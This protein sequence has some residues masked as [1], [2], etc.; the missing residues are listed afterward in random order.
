MKDELDLHFMATTPPLFTDKTRF[1]VGCS[2]GKDSAAALIWM[3]HESGIDP[4]Q[5]LSSF[6]DIKNDHQWTLAHVELLSKRVHPIETIHPRVGFFD[7]ALERHRFPSAKA[8]FCTEELKIYTT[9][10]HIQKLKYQGF[11]VIAVS[12]VRADESAG[13]ANKPEWDYSG[14]LLCYQWRPLIRW[15][16]DDVKA[17]H[18]KYGIPLNPL[19]DIGAQRV[20]CWPC[21]MSRKEEIRT[22]A[23]KFPER[24]DEIR[25]AER[26]FERRYG[27]YSSFFASD[28]IPERFRSKPHQLDDGT[29]IKVCTIDDVVKWSM[30]GN[31]A[32]GSYLDEEETEP[33]SCKSGFCE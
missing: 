32:Q 10:D 23:L 12:G 20:G 28:K 22:I 33:V 21:I 29:W 6:C 18:A 9:Q 30:T 13:R 25:K 14:T 3:R 11:D 5:I 8:R 7:L 1:H 15:T 19:Y 26:E 16:I 17:I 31:R 4:K 27:R 24:I 2:G